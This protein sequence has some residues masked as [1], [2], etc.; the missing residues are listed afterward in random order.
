ML[1]QPRLSAFRLRRPSVTLARD[2]R[3]GV[4]GVGSVNGNRFDRVSRRFAERR[5]SRREALLG[6]GATAAGLAISRGSAAIAQE[7]TPE[8][9]DRTSFLFVQSFRSGTLTPKRSDD[10]ADA[11]PIPGSGPE[12]VLTLVQGLGDTLYFSDRPDRIV[13]TVPTPVFLDGLGFTPVN[14]PNAALVA[15]LGDGNED[16]LIVELFNPVYDEATSSATYDVRILEDDERIDMTFR[17]QAHSGSHDA[18]TYGV[19]HLFIDD[20][21]DITGCAYLTDI[22]VL[23][24][25][26]AGTI[27]N[28]PYGQCWDWGCSPC[29]VSQND[30]DELCNQTYPICDGHCFAT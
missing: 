17:Q 21:A 16:L 15:D 7:A 2:R 8:A 18:A 9:V 24:P 28:G 4:I 20:C 12:Y 29:H 1:Q 11:T 26:V 13:G 3:H 10:S 23:V 6:S 14:P 27:P 30:L 5:F 19:S 25:V 22:V